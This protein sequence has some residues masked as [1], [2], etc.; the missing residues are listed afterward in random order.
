MYNTFKQAGKPGFF[1][2]QE[3]QIVLCTISVLFGCLSLLASVSQIKN[4]KKLFPAAL[5]A[6]GALVLLV[7]VICHINGQWFDFVFALF[8]TAAICAAA[9]WN[10]MK[11][12]QFHVQHH[13]V[14]I[15]LS[16]ILVIGFAVL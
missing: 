7:S 12:R 1:G 6:V 3:M 16:L 9:I 13:V 4:E 10:G 5:M 14:R 15:I 2:G 11:S 8:G